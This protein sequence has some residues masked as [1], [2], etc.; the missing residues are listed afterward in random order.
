MSVSLLRTVCTTALATLTA[1]TVI[2]AV[3]RSAEAAP[4]PPAPAPPTPAPAL[5]GPDDAANPGSGPAA[6]PSRVAELL[7][8]L[9]TL[10]RQAEDA[11][12]TH[13][14]AESRLKAQ[15]A[16]TARLG[17]E[18]TA[19]R[20]ALTEGRQEAGR[21][22]REQYQGHSELS[23]HLRLL[24]APDPRRALDE[25]HLMERAAAYR[26]ATVA[27]LETG[28]LKA[29]RLAAAS[30]K[31]LDRERALAAAR[32]K[33][34]D[35]ADAR[36]KKIEEMLAS[37]SPEQIA[38]LTTPQA[39]ESLINS[40]ALGAPAGSGSTGNGPTGTASAGKRTP[41][42]E[43]AD[44]VRYAVEQIGKPYVW[45]GTGPESYDCSG[46]TSRAWSAAGREIP[47]TS[48]QQWRELPRVP[49]RSLRP[50]DLVVY[51][52]E[53]TH[54]AIYLGDG[55]VVQAPRPGTVVKVSPLMANPVLGA[56]RPDPEGPLLTEYTPPPLPE[57]ATAG[58][59]TG[60]AQTTAPGTEADT[61]TDA[62]ADTTADADTDSG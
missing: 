29:R 43:G 24:L 22:A 15:R 14:T 41:T 32:R 49:V 47:R 61:K 57:G 28:A 40:G 36:L 56:V 20:D 48:Q 55:M 23:A 12:E 25:G 13:T 51:F 17:R 45:G 62:A 44:A 42:R 34:R 3:P 39:Q 11:G 35:T 8:R 53:A 31:A 6:A 30:R 9:K 16:E 7:T 1:V 38:G 2:T 5:P 59:D 46:L 27:R 33:A 37:L 18:L 52:P 54:V 19:A 26:M 58:S 60:Y 4:S 10:Y 50:G 21:L